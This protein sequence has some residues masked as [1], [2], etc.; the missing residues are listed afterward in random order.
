MKKL[1]CT[2]LS[3]P[4]YGGGD[5]YLVAL[6][7][8]SEI[9][10]FPVQRV[11]YIYGVKETLRRGFHAHKKLKQLIVCVSGECYVMLDDGSTR[12]TVHIASPSKG[13]LIEKPLWREMFNFSQ[14]CVLLVLASEHYTP[15][16]YIWD[17]TEFRMFVGQDNV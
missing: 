2:E 15:D 12:E 9:V 11:Y 5:G 3:L 10:P 17:Y 14:D 4:V 7:E 13:I 16:D 1:L 8:L 6:E